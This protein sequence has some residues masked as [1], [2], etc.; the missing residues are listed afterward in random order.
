V[1]TGESGVGAGGGP[2]NG[3]SRRA[4][5]TS[6][7][8]ASRRRN[9]AVSRAR[10][11][12][13]RPLDLGGLLSPAWRRTP[14]GACGGDRAAL[15]AQRQIPAAQ[16][17]RSEPEPR[18]R[19]AR[20]SARA[21][22]PRENCGDEPCSS[23]ADP[24]RSPPPARLSSCT[25]L[26]P[27]LPATFLAPRRRARA[28][29][30][31]PGG[32]GPGRP[33]DAPPSP[34]P[35]ARAALPCPLCRAGPGADLRL[36]RPNASQ[37]HAG[38]ACRVA[39]GKRATP[40]PLARREPRA[41]GAGSRHA[42]RG[43]RPARGRP[44]LLEGA[45]RGDT[46]RNPVLWIHGLARRRPAFSGSD[47][48]PA[49]GHRPGS[50]WSAP[51]SSARTRRTSPSSLTKMAPAGRAA[52]RPHARR[53]RQSTTTAAGAVTRPPGSRLRSPAP[54]G[55]P[56][57]TLCALAGAPCRGRVRRGEPSRSYADHSSPAPRAR[58]WLLCLA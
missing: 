36:P 21:P 31:R 53:A 23:P 1:S 37:R 9:P 17:S 20:R 24:H 5:L 3:D 22:R 56:P 19:R 41:P 49:R 47:A 42:P 52:G 7:L 4:G 14:P 33:G 25:A 32:S 2:G 34:S 13:R 50:T 16:A 11:R 55:Q 10:E 29:S 12:R 27:D 51:P 43:G 58:E 48:A 6:H 40:G 15:P 8:P 30:A 45:W 28:R 44:D 26:L 54:G 38:E 39:L 46:G 18:R 35:G 57:P